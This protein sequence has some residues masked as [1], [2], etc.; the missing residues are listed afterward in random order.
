[1][2]DRMLRAIIDQTRNDGNS[3]VPARNAGRRPAGRADFHG[4]P[5]PPPDLCTWRR[6]VR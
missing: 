3:G 5:G 1:M 6:R 2:F 4:F